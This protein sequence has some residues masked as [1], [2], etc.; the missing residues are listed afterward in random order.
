MRLRRKHL[1]VAAAALGLAGW[2]AADARGL[3]RH[4]R[5]QS[6]IAVY[7]QKARE[8]AEKNA[9]LRREIEALSGDS[10]ALEC[11]AREDLGLIKPNEVVF[12]FER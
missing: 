1:L 8:L 9:A 10:L 4:S 6:D 5:L 2:S 7:E 12:N 11:A 3:R